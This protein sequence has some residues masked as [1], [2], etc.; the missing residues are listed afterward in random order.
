MKVY[1]SGILRNYFDG[2]TVVD[3]AGRTIRQNLESLVNEYPAAKRVLFDEAGE[4]RRFVLVYADGERLSPESDWDRD[5]DASELLLVPAMAGDSPESLTLIPDEADAAEKSCGGEVPS[6]GPCGGAFSCDSCGADSECCGGEETCC[7]GEAGS[8]DSGALASPKTSRESL[9][10]EFR[11]YAVSLDDEQRARYRNHL[12]LSEIGVRGQKSLKAAKVV[13]AGAG[14][15]ASPVIL[16]LA[17]A[18]VGKIKIVD[19][20]EVDAADLQSQILHTARDLKRPKAAS[21][22]DSA[23]NVNRSVQIETEQVEIDADNVLALIEGYDLVIDCTDCCKSRYLINDACVLLGIPWIFG[24]ARRFE[25]QIALFE[26]KSGPC[27]RC[28]YPVPPPADILPPDGEAALFGPLAGLIGSAV[29]SEAL[30]LILGIGP[31]P[32]GKLLIVDALNLQFRTMDVNKN[33]SCPVCGKDPA[34]RTMDDFDDGAFRRPC[35]A[36]TPLPIE[37]LAP[38]ELARIVES[39]EAALIVDVREPHER[40]ALRFPGAVPIPIGQ[41]ERRL[42]EFDPGRNTVFVCKSGKRSLIA[43]QTLRQT[44]YAGPV[45]SLAGG[46]D[47]MKDIMFSHEGAW[48]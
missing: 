40:T 11:R 33:L 21:A 22:K 37:S 7:G 26:S 29:A 10:P 2:Q 44:G 18:G 45:F 32:A 4:F 12:V 43:A 41:I 42:R 23:R 34:I 17:A 28:L 15:L 35:G 14:A 13:V 6:C 3:G 16:Y 1:V 19:S 38:E 20:G 48:L 27:Y 30:K 31:S 25:G 5:L 24:A 46:I 47:A 39:G 8:C 36:E 9:I